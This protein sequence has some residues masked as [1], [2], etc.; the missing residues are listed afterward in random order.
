[1]W[2]GYYPIHIRS[3]ST[4]PRSSK[5]KLARFL[6][7]DEDNSLFPFYQGRRGGEGGSVER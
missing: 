5:N 4:L 1:M 6:D 3:I 2:E 7:L